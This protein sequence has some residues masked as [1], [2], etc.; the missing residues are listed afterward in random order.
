MHSKNDNIEQMIN[1]K[2]DGVTK[3]LLQ[4]LLSRY[5]IGWKRQ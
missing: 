4:S 1:D 3:K 2:E 5:Q